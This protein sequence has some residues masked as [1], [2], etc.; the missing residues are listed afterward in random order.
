MAHMRSEKV[1]NIIEKAPIAMLRENVFID[2]TH[3][4]I[5]VHR[6]KE[7]IRRVK[8]INLTTGAIINFITLEKLKIYLDYLN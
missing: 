4:Y 3:L 5:V 1:Y 2:D 6:S 8:R 7:S